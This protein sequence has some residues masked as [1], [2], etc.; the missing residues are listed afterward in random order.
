M[1]NIVSFWSTDFNLWILLWMTTFFCD[2]FHIYCFICSLGLSSLSL[3]FDLFHESSENREMI[4]F[5]CAQ[6]NARQ[7]IATAVGGIR[8][9][10]QRKSLKLRDDV[11]LMW[12][13]TFPLEKYHNFIIIIMQPFLFITM[14]RQHRFFIHFALSLSLSLVWRRKVLFIA[15]ENARL[16]LVQPRRD[17]FHLVRCVFRNRFLSLVWQRKK[18]ISW[19]I[20][21]SARQKQK[22][23]KTFGF[24]FGF[25]VNSRTFKMSH[26]KNILKFDRFVVC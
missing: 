10:R 23:K 17:F 8:C 26:E 9:R 7:W 21:I 16:R 24:I 6:Q 25:P 14:M 4:K 1:R 19:R 22:K 20:C 11:L 18:W 15:N 5:M 2:C 13:L 12:M 3:A